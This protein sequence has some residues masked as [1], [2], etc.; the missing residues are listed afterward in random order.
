MIEERRLASDLKNVNNKQ[1]SEKSF[2]SKVKVGQFKI[3]DLVLKKVLAQHKGVFFPN[4]ECPY[5]ISK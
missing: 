5:R 3:G 2:N 1:R 4:W